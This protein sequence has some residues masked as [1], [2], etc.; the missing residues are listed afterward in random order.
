[1]IAAQLPSNEE[2][3][4]QTLYKYDILDSL[5]EKEYDDIIKI[6][7]QIVNAPVSLISLVDRKRC[8]FKA[9][10]GLEGS[11][12]GRDIAFA[13]YVVLNPREP[14]VIEDTLTD[15]RFDDSPFVKTERP[16]RFYAGTPLVSENDYVIGS[17]CVIDYVPRQL[18]TQQIETL[19]ILAAQVVTRFDLHKQII[20]TQNLNEKLKQAYD[21]MEAFSYTVSHDLKEPL[22]SLKGYSEAVAEDYGDKIE[23]AGKEMLQKVVKSADKM[24]NLIED[25]LKYAEVSAHDLDLTEVNISQTVHEFIAEAKLPAKYEINVE[26]DIIVIADRTLT[27]RVIA[28]IAGNAV[29]Y[30]A[31]SENPFI[32]VKS[33]QKNGKTYIVISDN[34]IGFDPAK[35][36]NIFMPFRRLTADKNYRGTGVGLSAVKKIIDRHG[37]EIFFESAPGKGSS[38][39]F[40]F[41]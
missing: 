35:A 29:K 24:D 27:E 25:I 40:R 31:K 39:F 1:M 5:P 10:L 8:W 17:L 38:F 23:S 20:E 19:K 36:K 33:T 18:T 21:Q 28:N 22:R 30:S 16:M 7:A 3:R 14:T 12:A 11:E 13:S 32:E 41:E 4:L 15:G 9:Q 6:A 37:G 34:G 2:E 26:E